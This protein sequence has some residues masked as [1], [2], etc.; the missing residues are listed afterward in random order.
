MGSFAAELGAVLEEALG[1]RLLLQQGEQQEKKG[2]RGREKGKAT[3]RGIRGGA[4]GMSPGAYLRVS[5]K[6]LPNC[7]RLGN[8]FVFA[9]CCLSIHSIPSRFIPFHTI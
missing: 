2:E 7:N 4:G 8:K 3:A 5:E 6:G 1:R 9:P